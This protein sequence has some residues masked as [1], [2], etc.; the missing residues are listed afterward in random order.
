MWRVGECSRFG[1]TEGFDL[2]MTSRN[3]VDFG[4]PLLNNQIQHGRPLQIVDMGETSIDEDT[5]MEYI[6][7]MRD[8]Y[9][10]DKVCLLDIVSCATKSKPTSPVSPPR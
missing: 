4:L 8:H 10:A 2:T 1:I 7:E 9:T 3:A 6:E 5:F